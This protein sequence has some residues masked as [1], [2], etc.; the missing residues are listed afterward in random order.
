M[1]ATAYRPVLARLTTVLSVLLLVTLAAVVLSMAVGSVHYPPG[2]VAGY[3]WRWASG[4]GPPSGDPTDYEIIIGLRL[5]R[6]AL[7]LLVGLSLGTAGA[8]LQG[9]LRNPLAEP[10]I[11]GVSA[12]A[13][14]G[15]V[16]VIVFGW[17]YLLGGLTVPAGAFISAVMTLGAVYAMARREGRMRPE[18][19][20]LAGAALGAFSWAGMTI[21]LAMKGEDAQRIIFWMLGSLSL[22][23]EGLK[24]LAWLVLLL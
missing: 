13:A 19:F 9:V 7:G 3:L 10:Y 17:E 5:P 12:G 16:A 8:L 15:A 2:Q 4:A 22:R 21:A 18:S 20:L 14:L 11:I 23:D 24:P 6:T 1:T